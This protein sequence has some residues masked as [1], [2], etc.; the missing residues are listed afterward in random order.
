MAYVDYVS[1]KTKPISEPTFLTLLY[2]QPNG[3]L[4]ADMVRDDTV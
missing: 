4:D 1:S 3:R 2:A